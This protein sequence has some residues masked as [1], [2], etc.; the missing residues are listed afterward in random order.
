[1][2]PSHAQWGERRSRSLRGYADFFG[3]RGEGKGGEAM[4]MSV[5]PRVRRIVLG[6]LAALALALAGTSAWAL[7]PGA[8]PSIKFAAVEVVTTDDGSPRLWASVEVEIPGGSVPL[9]VS[10]VTVAVPGGGTFTM[11]PDRNDLVAER[12]YFLDLTSAGVSG[13]PA[14]TYTFTVT[15]TAGGSSTATD[16]LGSTGGLATSTSLAVSGAVQVAA[17]PGAP[18]V[19]LLNLA[20]NPTPTISWTPA[21]GALNQ[22]VRIRGG[23]QDLDLFSRFTGNATIA[24]MTLP[25]GVMVSGRRYLV[26][27]DSY[28]NVNASGCSIPQLTCQDSNARSRRR[29]EV[30][31]QGPEIFLTFGS[32]TYGVG[33]TL[34]VTTRV[35]N[36]GPPVTVNA[37]AWIGLP[38]GGVINILD[39]DNLVIPTNVAGDFYNGTIGFSYTFNGTEP[40]GKY[41]VGLR[42]MD[43]DTGET[44]ALATRTFAK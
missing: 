18:P 23:W 30:I 38:A 27:L 9:N 4:M 40:S 39:T 43:P 44:V 34:N 37:M 31:T 5:A 17:Q 21:P 3:A 32:G 28:D 13:F 20:T 29:I 6:T 25:A 41:V 42:L 15:D 2:L 14:G 36:T 11:P 33:Q 35:Y 22:R 10:S 24:S 26:R 1:M 16:N 7:G 8:P 12:S 19:Y